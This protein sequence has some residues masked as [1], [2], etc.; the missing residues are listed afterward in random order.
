MKPIGGMFQKGTPANVATSKLVG[1]AITVILTT[2]RVMLVNV[3]T[4]KQIGV[5]KIA[6]EMH[7]KDTNATNAGTRRPTGI[8][9]IVVGMPPKDTLAKNVIT[10]K[11]IGS[12]RIVIGRVQ[13]VT[14]ARSVTIRKLTGIAKNATGIPPK[15]TH[16]RSVEG[17]NDYLSSVQLG[18]LIKNY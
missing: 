10:S 13:K 5:A 8:A 15:V 4:R 9:I 18:I 12:A 2:L 7:L 3:E 16:A 14:H 1:D 17:S 11:P 6:T